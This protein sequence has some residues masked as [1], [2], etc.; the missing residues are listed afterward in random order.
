M[1]KQISVFLNYVEVFRNRKEIIWLLMAS[2]IIFRFLQG[3]WIFD[4][5]LWFFFKRFSKSY[6]SGHPKIDPKISPESK[7]LSEIIKTD[8]KAGKF[9]AH[10]HP[11][12]ISNRAKSYYSFHWKLKGDRALILIHL[13]N[14][15][16]MG[17][18][19]KQTLLFFLGKVE[20]NK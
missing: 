4:F 20:T 10:L 1:N 19:T 5:F 6:W 14:L 16:A 3:S 17:S 2:P 13:D 11:K 9:F 7:K 15:M 8:S 18:W 12:K